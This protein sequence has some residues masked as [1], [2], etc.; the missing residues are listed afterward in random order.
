[1]DTPGTPGASK[2]PKPLRVLLFHPAPLL[3]D[4]LALFLSTQ[5]D[6][7]AIGLSDVA[8]FMASV[9]GAAVILLSVHAWGPHELGTIQRI[10]ELSSA[11]VIF[12]G[13]DNSSSAGALAVARGADGYIHERADPVA[14]LAAIRSIAGGKKFVVGDGLDASA[15]GHQVLRA[16]PSRLSPREI[17]VLAHVAGDATAQ[18]IASALGISERT[19][20]SHLQHAYRKLGVHGRMSAVLAAQDNAGDTSL[21][22]RE[23][24]TEVSDSPTPERSSEWRT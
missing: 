4:A 10:R 18:Q 16:A 12:L 22:R 23:A 24:H 14:L 15:N 21:G 11:R 17:E 19:V 6:I 1:M 2:D 13:L 9:P 20:H 5:P 3:A 7:D 8:E